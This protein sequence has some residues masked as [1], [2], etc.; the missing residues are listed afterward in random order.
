[1][2]G[3]GKGNGTLEKWQFLGIYVRFLG[4]TYFGNQSYINWIFELLNLVPV[5]L[6]VLVTCQSMRLALSKKLYAHGTCNM[7][8]TTQQAKTINDLKEWG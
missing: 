7:H 2:M 8:I 6:A 3:L 5:K 1:M 4:C